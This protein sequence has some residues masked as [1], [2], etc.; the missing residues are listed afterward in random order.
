MVLGMWLRITIACVIYSDLSL[1]CLRYKVST[2]VH[3]VFPETLELIKVR[4]LGFC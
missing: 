1:D 4:I 3:A 2:S